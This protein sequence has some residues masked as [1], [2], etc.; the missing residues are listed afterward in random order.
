MNILVKLLFLTSFNFI[1]LQ[2]FV[3]KSKFYQLKKLKANNYGLKMVSNEEIII[4][5]KE[6]TEMILQLGQDISQQKQ[7]NLELIQNISQQ[8]QNNLELKQNNLE[9]KQI[10]VEQTQM[11]LEL[12]KNISQLDGKL[13]KVVSF[14]GTL[15]VQNIACQVLLVCARTQPK[16]KLISR[17]SK[18]FTVTSS[19]EIHLEKHLAM[20]YVF[21]FLI[22]NNIELTALQLD[23]II[24][25]RN[26]IIHYQTLGLMIQS[27]D[28]AI[29]L[30]NENAYLL[31]N[32]P[33]ECKVIVNYKTFFRAFRLNFNEDQYKG[34]VD[35][36]SL[37]SSGMII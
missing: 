6:Q 15:A 35:D 11:I 36:V 37:D 2:P 29:E 4:K 14:S 20:E 5:L 26:E 23:S 13:T 32:F 21:K 12:G 34:W 19:E 17:K 30:V 22:Q 33:D 25:A 3:L 10:S 31:K 8:K 16:M 9:L 18:Y 7:I 24:S 27:I 1:V 28:E